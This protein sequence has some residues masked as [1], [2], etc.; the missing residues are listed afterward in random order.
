MTCQFFFTPEQPCE[1]VRAH[2]HGVCSVCGEWAISYHRNRWTHVGEP[3]APRRLGKW[4]A[5]HGA[6]EARFVAG[7]TPERAAA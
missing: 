2:I 1:A 4:V 5:D 6:V 7:R 3:C